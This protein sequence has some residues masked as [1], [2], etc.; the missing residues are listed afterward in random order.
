MTP[1]ML[2]ATMGDAQSPSPSPRSAPGTGWLL[3]AF[4]PCATRASTVCLVYVLNAPLFLRLLSA[5]QRRAAFL[6]LS[7]SF[8]S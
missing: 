3:P 5:G 8:T 4:I 6:P 2:L 7:L 1:G